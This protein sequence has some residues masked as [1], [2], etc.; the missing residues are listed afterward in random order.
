MN[1]RGCG[2]YLPPW[3]KGRGA[4]CEPVSVQAGVECVCSRVVHGLAASLQLWQALF[5]PPP[6]GHFTNSGRNLGFGLCEGTAMGRE[7]GKL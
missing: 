6:R 7:N 5:L 3:G 1:E 2:R 4:V